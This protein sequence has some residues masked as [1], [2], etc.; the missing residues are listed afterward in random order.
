MVNSSKNINYHNST[1]YEIG[2]LNNLITKFLIK[3]E[4]ICNFETA[5]N[6]ASPSPD[7]FTGGFYQTPKKKLTPIMYNLCQK[8]KEV[9]I[10]PSF[11]EAITLEKLQTNNPH[12]FI[13]ENP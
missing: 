9:E 13:Y 2:N 1:Q 6:W 5:E 8:I 3:K 10:I 4:F 11:H 12:K 7:G